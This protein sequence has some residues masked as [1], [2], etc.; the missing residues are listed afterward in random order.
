MPTRYNIEFFEHSG[1][2]LYF[3]INMNLKDPIQRISFGSNIIET[4]CERQPNGRNIISISKGL[5]RK[6]QLPEFVRS[7]YLFE[8]DDILVI[9]PLVGIFSSGFTPYQIK[10]IG[11]RSTIFEKLLSVQSSV[12][13]V[14]FLFGEQHIDWDQ[15]MIEGFFFTKDGWE[16]RKVPFPNVVYDRLPNRR[17]EKLKASKNVKEKLSQEY[18]IP[19]YNPGF[20]NKLDV[21]ERLLQSDIAENYLPET[22]PFSS[23]SQMEQLLSKY[24]HIYIKPMNGSLGLGVHQ[25]LYNREEQAYYCRYHD[26]ANHLMKFKSLEA[27]MKKVF[28][29]KNLERMI[30][31]QGIPLMRY[32]HLPVDF[33]VHVNKNK[34]GNWEV[35]AM[36]AKVAGNGS[37]TTHVKNGGTIKTIEEVFDH[38]EECKSC[39]EKLEKAA[40]DLASIIEEQMEG[41]IGEIGYDFGIDTKGNVWLFEANSKPGRSIFKHP[42]LKNSDILTRKLSLSFAVFLT[43]KAVKKPE[44]LFS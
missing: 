35:S 39:K 31:Q 41:I 25:I 14:P 42:H 40:L 18:M 19:W 2:K 3:P 9:G 1:L 12:G 29:K 33:R 38:P 15:G 28:G 20:F 44:E 7:I 34:D 13:V 22:Y 5:A 24:G 27:L 37:P 21:Y 8:N 16:K 10:P 26:E 11:E 23:F 4:K 30:V 43:E 32:N 17:S 6:L 36:A